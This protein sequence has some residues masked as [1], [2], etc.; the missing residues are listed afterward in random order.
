MLSIGQLECV[1]Y[2]IAC[3]VLYC[4]D[5]DKALIS[6]DDCQ[7]RKLHIKLRRLVVETR[8]GRFW[9]VFPLNYA[10]C[11][12]YF[13]QFIYLFIEYVNLMRHALG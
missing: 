7:E 8:H 6:E 4:V 9:N 5:N 2:D 11:Y 13:M 1:S 12:N 10:C 3:G